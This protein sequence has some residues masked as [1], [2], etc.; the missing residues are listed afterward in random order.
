MLRELALATHWDNTLN[1]T[2]VSPPT[3]PLAPSIGSTGSNCSTINCL[4]VTVHT[5]LSFKEVEMRYEGYLL[6]PA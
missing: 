2:D 5:V 1:G 3:F 6:K 4:P